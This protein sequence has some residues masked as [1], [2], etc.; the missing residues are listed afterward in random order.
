MTQG[1]I[2]EVYTVFFHIVWLS[3]CQ[4][5]NPE[6]IDKIYPYHINT[7]RREA[8]IVFLILDVYCIT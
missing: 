6:N 4:K 5:W 8:Q 3:Q 7:K 1:V 2:H